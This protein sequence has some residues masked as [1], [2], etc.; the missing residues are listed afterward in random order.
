MFVTPTVSVSDRE[1][2]SHTQS[3]MMKTQ[4]HTHGL[5]CAHTQM[6]HTHTHTE[7]EIHSHTHSDIHDTYIPTWMQT[8]MTRTLSQTQTYK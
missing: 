1:T 7:K 2:N 4:I 6:T 8:H 3:N 5:T